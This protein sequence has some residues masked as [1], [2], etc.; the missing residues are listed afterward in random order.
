MFLALTKGEMV[1]AETLHFAQ[2]DK[3]GV[4]LS[5]LCEGSRKKSVCRTMLVNVIPRCIAVK[6]EILH[7]QAQSDRKKRKWFKI[8]VKV[9][10]PH[11]I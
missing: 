5:R 11:F 9:D 8:V 6:A 10:I 2:S 4:V 7:S 3:N 1:M